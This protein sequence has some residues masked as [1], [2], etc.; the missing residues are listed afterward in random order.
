[1]YMESK[2]KKKKVLMSLLEEKKWRHRCREWEGESKQN[3]W[4]Q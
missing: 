2:R 4:T 3:E 1:M